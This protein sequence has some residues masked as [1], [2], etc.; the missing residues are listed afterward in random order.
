MKQFTITL[1]K[2]N[3]DP[4]GTLKSRILH[5][6]ATKF[7]F[8]KWHGID[9]PEDEMSSISFAG[10][11]DKLIFGLNPDAEFAALNCPCKNCP[12]LNGIRN[13]NLPQDL[14][15]ALYRLHKYAAE[16]K[17]NDDKGYDFLIGN[18]PVRIYQKF[19]QIGN[20]V[21]PFE[22]PYKFLKY[23]DE[24]DQITIIDILINVS[25]ADEISDL[26]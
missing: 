16:V 18:T 14:D 26:F 11:G 20:T 13:Y 15:L 8:L 12:L 5:E 1:P 19:I 17:N 6:V 23:K 25:N 21:I 7:P 3:I 22:D 10:P 24:A 4:K 2:K 9:T